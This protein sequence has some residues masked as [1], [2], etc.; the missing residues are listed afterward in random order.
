MIQSGATGETVQSLQL[1]LQ[2]RGQTLEVDGIFGPQTAQAVRAY[3]QAQHLSVD[4]IVG[5]QTWQSL[6][7]TVR[8]GSQGQGVRASSA[9]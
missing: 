6:I 4:G 8:N 1:L 5:P 9:S 2:Q 7:V 3:Q